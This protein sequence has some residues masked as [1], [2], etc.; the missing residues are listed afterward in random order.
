MSRV[1]CSLPW[2]IIKSWGVDAIEELAMRVVDEKYTYACARPRRPFTNAIDRP[3]HQGPWLR[4]HWTTRA[5]EAEGQ[6]EVIVT[7]KKARVR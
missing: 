7:I 6:V 5:R 1:L 3:R 4:H 2:R